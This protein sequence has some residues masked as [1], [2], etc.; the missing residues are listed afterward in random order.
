MLCGR[1]PDLRSF[2]LTIGT[3]VTPA[4]E[5]FTPIFAYLRLFVFVI[6]THTWWTDGQTDRRAD[7]RTRQD[8]PAM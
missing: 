6:W 2:N 7:G 1:P 8:T 4:L 5:M 3:P